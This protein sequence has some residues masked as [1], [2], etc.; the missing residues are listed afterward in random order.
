LTTESAGLDGDVV[1]EDGGEHH[2]AD[3]NRLN[4]AL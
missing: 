2:P 4:A 1:K 3:G